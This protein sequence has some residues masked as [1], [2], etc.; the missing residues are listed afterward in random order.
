MENTELLKKIESLESK[1]NQLEP[2]Q[3][4]PGMLGHIRSVVFGM[5]LTVNPSPS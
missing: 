4:K 3:T 1:V 2:T 5:L